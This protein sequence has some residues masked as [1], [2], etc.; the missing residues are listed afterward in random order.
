MLGSNMKFVVFVEPG[1][2]L[3]LNPELFAE[4]GL[5]CL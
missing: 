4:W 1:N 2:G 3:V 5:S